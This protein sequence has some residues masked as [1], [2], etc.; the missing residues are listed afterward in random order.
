MNHL[1][2]YRQWQAEAAAYRGPDVAGAR[3]GMDD[4]MWAE[5]LLLA[6]MLDR[7]EVT[8]DELVREAMA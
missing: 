5:C 4:A 8:M 6:E 2:I 7:G 1:S 3:R